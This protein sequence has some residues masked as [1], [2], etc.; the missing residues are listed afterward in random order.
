MSEL[1]SSA[2]PNGESQGRVFTVTYRQTPE[3][4]S[5]Y[6]PESS[7]KSSAVP[8]GALRKAAA[9]RA[10]ER[11]ASTEMPFSAERCPLS[12]G[13]S[14]S[15]ASSPASLG[16]VSDGAAAAVGQCPL[17]F[18][19]SDNQARAAASAE[20]SD[21]ALPLID[22]AMLKLHS[23]QSG[24][25]HGSKRPLLVSVQG[26]VLDVSPKSSDASGASAQPAIA[27]AFAPDGELSICAGHDATRLLAVRL[28][29]F[30][31]REAE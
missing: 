27:K 22:L 29:R 1:H 31:L 10:S 11:A 9:D 20:A 30:S 7:S 17:G 16:R 5:Y 13:R 12:F 8:L 2:A 15:S 21:A 14:T 18:G 4:S 6:A 23:G 25:E 24:G 19:R 28:F 26:I 3:S